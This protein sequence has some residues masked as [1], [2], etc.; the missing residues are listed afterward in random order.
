MNNPRKRLIG[1]L[2]NAHA[3]EIAAAFAYRGHW[4]SLRHS[5][6]R[7]HIKQI[8]AEEWMHRERVGFWLRELKS[9]PKAGRE[10]FFHCLG[11][12]LG[13][14]C[15]FSGWFMPMYFAGK[16]ENQNVDEYSEAAKFAA[17]IGMSECTAEMIEMSE[18]E[19]RHEEF[20]SRGCQKSLLT[21]LYENPVPVELMLQMAGTLSSLF[22]KLYRGKTSH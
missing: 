15:Y 4:K 9:Q 14:A 16:L 22:P 3:G 2:Q 21:S 17:E 7:E 20:F 19:L 1:I 12:I 10:M 6:D 11:R 8:E 18:T 5:N 13:T